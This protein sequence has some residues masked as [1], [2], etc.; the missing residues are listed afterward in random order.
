MEW[1]TPMNQWIKNKSNTLRWQLRVAQVLLSVCIFWKWSIFIEIVDPRYR[2]LGAK[3][4]LHMYTYIRPPKGAINRFA[5][6][7]Q[8][9]CSAP[10]LIYFVCEPERNKLFHQVP[11]ACV[12]GTHVRVDGPYRELIY[13]AGSTHT[14]HLFKIRFSSN[15]WIFNKPL[16]YRIIKI[17]RTDIS[18]YNSTRTI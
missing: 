7:Y 16:F 9:G 14:T 6:S 12:T 18:T 3:P 4:A 2:A 1:C 10:T 17:T 15:E 8:V 13:G 5:R 11:R